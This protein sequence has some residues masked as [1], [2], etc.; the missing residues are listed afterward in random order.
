ML[1]IFVMFLF[2]VVYIP[3][4]QLSAPLVIGSRWNCLPSFSDIKTIPD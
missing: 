2:Y 3:H 1:E 4:Q